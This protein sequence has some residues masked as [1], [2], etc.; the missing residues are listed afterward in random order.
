MLVGVECYEFCS[1]HDR[2]K[3]PCDPD[4]PGNDHPFHPSHPL[5]LTHC[6]S[7][8]RHMVVPQITGAR[9]P[10][11]N[12]V[13]DDDDAHSTLY[14]KMALALHSPWRMTAPPW[15]NDHPPDTAFA[16]CAFSATA[17][18][19]LANHQD[20]YDQQRLAH[21]SAK[22][23]RA[24]AVLDVDASNAN[25]LNLDD[26][27]DGGAAL[28][29]AIAM[30]EIG[31]KPATRTV[32]KN[33]VAHFDLVEA[34]IE[35]GSCTVTAST[36]DAALLASVAAAAPPTEDAW[37]PTLASIE[38]QAEPAATAASDQQRDT[39]RALLVSRALTSAAEASVANTRAATATVVPITCPSLATVS[40]SFRLNREQDA[41]FRVTC[42]P[43]L[44]HYLDLSVGEDDDATAA[45]SPH[46]GLLGL[47]GTND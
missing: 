22:A 18:S 2:K 25:G 47:H 29:D 40:A 3:K 23:R 20:H 45:V 26:Y 9:M 37:K 36:V 4:D 42:L 1:E 17:T 6:I 19:R 34:A 24:A 14:F 31:G 32:P 35:S 38:P 28:L 16:A 21:A 39:P 27:L 43:L 8:R 15:S 13:S 10:D 41:A 5:A 7:K 46:S 11:L 30:A 12:K 33:V 44:R